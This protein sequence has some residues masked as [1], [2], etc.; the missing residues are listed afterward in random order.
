MKRKLSGYFGA[1]TLLL[2]GAIVLAGSWA[3]YHVPGRNDQ[4]QLIQLGQCVYHGGRMYVDCWENK[5]PGIAWINALGLALTR[6]NPIGPWIL[7]GAVEVAVF[8]H[9]GYA[10][11]RTS[12]TRMGLSRAL[13][14]SLRLYDT[15]SINPDFYASMLGRPQLPY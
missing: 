15:S 3:S 14:Y 10:Q 5:P 8:C 11:D 7:P 9:V 1:L 2:I 13:V 4:Y 6:G 12:R